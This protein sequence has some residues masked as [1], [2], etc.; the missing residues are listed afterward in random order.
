MTKKTE[1]PFPVVYRVSRRSIDGKRISISPSGFARK[2]VEIGRLDPGCEVK[3]MVFEVIHKDGTKHFVGFSGFESGS[4]CL[5]LIL[6]EKDYE[7]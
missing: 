2:M 6:T 5:T 3:P 4:R 1:T 7:D